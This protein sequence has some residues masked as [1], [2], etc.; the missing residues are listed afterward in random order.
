MESVTFFQAK[1]GGG[2]SWHDRSSRGLETIIATKYYALNVQ[3]IRDMMKR[4]IWV[5]GMHKGSLHDSVAFSGTT[6]MTRVT[7]MAAKLKEHGFFMNADLAFNDYLSSEMIWIEC[8]FGEYNMR[9]GFCW[10]PLRFALDKAGMIIETCMLLHNFTI[11]E[12]TESFTELEEMIRKE[13]YN[14]HDI[15]AMSMSAR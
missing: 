15:L 4:F 14:L 1:Q 6:Q 7:S 9:W 12:K 3:A 8:A 5:S 13:G 2:T 10:R 11:D